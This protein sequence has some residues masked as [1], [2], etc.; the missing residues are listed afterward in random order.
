MLF[1]K[2]CGNEL[3]DGQVCNCKQAQ[4]NKNSSQAM[5]KVQ[6]SASCLSEVQATSNQFTHLLSLIKI[7]IKSPKEAVKK[8]VYENHIVPALILMG[9]NIIVSILFFASIISLLISTITKIM[10]VLGTVAGGLIKVD[11]PVFQLILSGVLATVL[12]FGLSS[13]ALFIISK[14]NKKE[15]ELKQAFITV[16]IHSLFPTILLLI[17]MICGLMAWW[18]QLVFALAAALLWI[19]NACSDIQVF[20]GGDLNDTMKSTII[21]TGIF[22][23]VAAVFLVVNFELCKWN[24]TTAA[25]SVVSNAASGIKNILEMFTGSL[26]K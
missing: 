5:P 16:S 11:Y 22:F 4:V 7:Y 20:C 8:A 21:I 14:T 13:L 25:N 1:C 15:F 3:Q 6:S 2:Y 9:I 17:S 10:G 24:I 12:T 18:L 26:Y 23:I 19:I